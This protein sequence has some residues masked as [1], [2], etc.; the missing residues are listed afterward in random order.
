MKE[1]KIT[2]L[3]GIFLFVG[4]HSSLF[5]QSEKDSTYFLS[6]GRLFISPTFSVNNRIAENDDQILRFIEDQYKLEWNIDIN[7]GYF[8]KDNFSAGAQ[9]SYQSSREDIE[10]VADSKELTEN[11][12]GRGITFSPNIRNYF[13][14]GNFKVFNQT[15]VD[16]SYGEEIKRVYAEDDEDKI[17]TKEINYGISIQPGLAFFVSELIAVEASLK[18]LGW[19]SSHIE[20]TINDNEDEQSIV[21]KHDVNFSVDLLTLNIGIGIY[22]DQINK[23]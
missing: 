2:F 22:L 20:S 7:V 18:L 15:N 13:G 1:I 8:I 3:L 9:L 5:A 12:Y 19:E 11:S 16:F 21:T 6:K 10:Y 17:F 14:K 23:H 4:S